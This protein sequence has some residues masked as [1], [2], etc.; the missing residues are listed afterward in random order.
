MAKLKT[1]SS[2]S[3]MMVRYKLIS[4]QYL[5]SW[6][7]RGDNVPKYADY[8]GYVNAKELYPELEPQLRSLEAYYREVLDGKSAA[9]YGRAIA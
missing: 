1:E 7:A 4:L 6:G 3:D 2:S 8:L 9:P 5:H